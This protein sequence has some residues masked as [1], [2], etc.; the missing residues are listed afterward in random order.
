MSAPGPSPQLADVDP[1]PYRELLLPKPWVWLMPVVF[2]GCLGVAY[3]YAYGAATGWLVGTATA[4]LLLLWLGLGTSTRIVVDGSTVAAGR[5]RLPT[6]FVGQVRALDAD[7]AFR[8]R[9]ADAD[10]RA[11]LVLRPWASPR[12][13]VMEVTDPEDPH[14]YWLITTRRPQQLADALLAA[15]TAARAG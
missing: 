10:A 12:A 11:H 5:A 6:R 15:R 7:E 3:G 14:P 4:G 13:V 2:A 9:T 1:L 8:T